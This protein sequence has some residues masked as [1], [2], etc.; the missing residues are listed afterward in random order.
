MRRIRKFIYLLQREKILFLRA[1]LLLVDSRFSLQFRQFKNVARHF[2]R[3]ASAQQPA[4][5]CSV[6]SV[7]VAALLN[8]ASCFIPPPTCLSKAL[9]G[10]VL[11][12]S[13]GYQTLLHIGIA[14]EGGS[15]LDAH[16]WLTLD[17]S[18]IVGDRSDLGRYRELPFVFDNGKDK[19]GQ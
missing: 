17:G 3:K 15:M 10:S 19:S 4:R 1:L 9:A 11:F 14:K 16:A 6:S 8:A 5:V 18:V 12:R 2:S 7:R 13:C